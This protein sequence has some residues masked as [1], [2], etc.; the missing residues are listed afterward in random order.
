MVTKEALLTRQQDLYAQ[1]R[2][3]EGTVTAIHGALQDVTYWLNYLKEEKGKA[4][5]DVE[6]S[7]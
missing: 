1:L 2:E 6:V 7:A 4:D 3:A 5:A